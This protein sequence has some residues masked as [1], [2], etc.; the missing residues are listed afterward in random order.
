[1]L[2]HGPAFGEH[3]QSWTD[4]C[5]A[6]LARVGGARINSLDDASN[7]ARVCR[8]VLD[9]CKEAVLLAHVWTCSRSR[10]V[11]PLVGIAGQ[12][13]KPHWPYR[14]AYGVPAD[15]LR[16]VRIETGV[17]YGSLGAPAHMEQFIIERYKEDRVILCNRQKA[18]LI[19]IANAKNPAVLSAECRQALTAALTLELATALMDHGRGVRET[20]YKEYQEALRRAIYIDSIQSSEFVPPDTT[21]ARVRGAEDGWY[22][23]AGGYDE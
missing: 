13:G 14:Y 19:Y 16:A 9:T 10:A 5:N 15:F 20:Y 2:W 11:L 3:M 1:M 12:D 6:A 4:I 7:E 23:P 17:P 18:E 22:Y 21:Y 8:N